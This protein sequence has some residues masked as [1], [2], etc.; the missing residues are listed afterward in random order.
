MNSTTSNTATMLLLFEMRLDSDPPFINYCTDDMICKLLIWTPPPTTTITNSNDN[1][2]TITSEV[3]HN[4]AIIEIMVPGGRSK[5]TV[6]ALRHTIASIL[7]ISIDQFYLIYHNND[8]ND[9]I[10]L[11]Q[12]QLP[13]IDNEEK[14]EESHKLM[15]V[16]GILPGATIIVEIINSGKVSTYSI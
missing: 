5:A 1:N 2:N 7:H 16:Y 10:L 3:S 11:S 12:S 15:K 6:S 13:H 14:E 4:D 8:N 9:V